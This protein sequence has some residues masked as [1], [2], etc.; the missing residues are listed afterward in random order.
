M[1]IYPRFLVFAFVIISAANIAH[2]SA[3]EAVP[4]KVS[5]RDSVRSGARVFGD[6]G[7]M[8]FH[9][10]FHENVTTRFL[11]LKTAPHSKELAKSLALD[12]QQLMHIKSLQPVKLRPEPAD[13]NLKENRVISN[14]QPDEQIV[15]PAY[16]EFLRSNQ[17]NRLD[18][19]AIRFDGYSALTRKSRAI[20][21][22]RRELVQ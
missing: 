9:T 19:L 21:C 13:R 10:A 16:F 20:A 1:K 11:L 2:L 12:D 4:L 17:L 8:L 6:P 18:V 14:D 15:D 3:Q 5:P 7:G 22:R